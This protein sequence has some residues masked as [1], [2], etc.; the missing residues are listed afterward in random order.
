APT[1]EPAVPEPEPTQPEPATMTTPEPA[2]MD[3]RSAQTIATLLPA[4]QPRFRAFYEAANKAM[5]PH[6]LTVKFISGTRTYAEQDALYAQGR[7]TTGP[8]V[9]NAKAGHSWHNFGLA[10]DVG[11]FKGSKYLTESP[12]YNWLGPIG[13]AC[14][15]E[16]GGRWKTPDRPHYQ[17]PTGLT[18]AQMRERVAKG[19]PIV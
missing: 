7:T 8:K 12:A 16:W 5:Q 4:V 10:V 13:E 14:G 17:F 9:T 18:M 1:P 2:P 3:N 15:L 6:G 11:V 19:E